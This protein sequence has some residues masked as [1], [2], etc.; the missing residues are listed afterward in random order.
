MNTF[1]VGLRSY[2][3][4]PLRPDRLSPTISGQATT[5]LTLMLCLASSARSAVLVPTALDRPMTRPAMNREGL[6][7]HKLNPFSPGNGRFGAEYTGWI[8]VR[9]PA[10]G[11]TG[12]ALLGFDRYDR[13]FDQ[14]TT[15]LTDKTPYEA[16]S[17]VPRDLDHANRV[18]ASQAGVSI[19][20]RQTRGIA[21]PAAGA[22]SF[23]FPLSH[24]LGPAPPNGQM[25]L[26]MEEQAIM[27]QNVGGNRINVYYAQDLTSGA[28]GE[29]YYPD[30]TAGGN[31]EALFMAE[32]V[33]SGPGFIPITRNTYVHELTHFTTNGL[34]LHMQKAAPDQSH[35][36]DP[37]NVLGNPQYDPA[38]NGTALGNIPDNDV[39]AGPAVSTGNG[40]PG[41][42]PKVGGVS[43][44]KRSQLFT[45]SAGAPAP[46]RGVFGDPAVSPYLS[47]T[48]NLTAADK[49]D[50]NFAV[51]DWI[52]EDLTG[53]DAFVGGRESLYFTTGAPV[54]PADPAATAD[55]G[56]KEKTGLGVFNNPGYHKGMF[57]MIDVF[58][59]NAH[60]A[61]YDV[62]NGGNASFRAASL[63]YDVHFVLPGNVIVPA[64]PVAVFT[65]GW[66]E[67]TFADDWLTRWRSPANAIGALITAHRYTDQVTGESIG[68]VQIDA[69]IASIPEP[70]T[71]SLLGLGALGFRLLRSRSAVR[72]A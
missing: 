44:L 50:W 23:D 58:S 38:Q 14:A 17:D 53:A 56:G 9:H 32:R 41:G 61:D 65:E 20:E 10:L 16:K 24:G 72:D 35:S 55:N 46:N 39:V 13:R 29:T 27:Q 12:D 68:N 69:V 4:Q 7:E 47:S 57:R 62:D 5:C 52:T 42:V 19:I 71:L 18:Y 64:A 36:S 28:Y 40:L 26:P 67:D 59:L 11:G 34:A 31:N 6:L 3:C 70:A 30:F 48:Y 22:G 43:Q 54:V 2:R 49:V 21:S 60:Y 66:S 63:D 37:R 51:D 15:I 33:K 1:V 25:G 45:P 8:D